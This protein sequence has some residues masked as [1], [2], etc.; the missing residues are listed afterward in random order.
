MRQIVS[1]DALPQVRGLQL[2]QDLQPPPPHVLGE[3]E[4]IHLLLRSVKVADRRHALEHVRAVFVSPQKT[5][6]LQPGNGRLDLG[7]HRAPALTKRNLGIRY[8]KKLARREHHFVGV[9]AP[10]A[11]DRTENLGDIPLRQAALGCQ[12][13]LGLEVALGEQQ[14]TVRGLA[15][16]SRPARFLQVILDGTRYVG[17]HHQAHV[18]LVDAHAECVCRDDD[19]DIAGDEGVL[20]PLLVGRIET[21]MEVIGLPSLTRAGRR[22]AARFACAGKRRRSRH[23]RCAGSAKPVALAGFGAGGS[24]AFGDGFGGGSR[25][26]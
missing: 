2:T 4:P 1:V 20:N 18:F 5:G 19:R 26:G 16:P 12:V 7:T 22:Q 3:V 10:R 25:H 23:R 6:A 8:P 14:N 11:A 17:V 21:G 13:E 15:V 24:L 9:P